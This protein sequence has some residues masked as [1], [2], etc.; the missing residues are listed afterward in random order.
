[1]STPEPVIRAITPEEREAGRQLRV[2]AFTTKARMEPD[3]EDIYA[4]DLRRIGAFVEDRMVTHT[5][6]WEFGQWFLGRRVPMAGI[7]GVASSPEARG[8]GYGRLA[9][10]ALVEQCLEDGDVVSALY[11][12]LPSFYRGLGWAIGGVWLAR[13]LYTEGLTALPRPAADVVVRNIDQEADAGDIA[14]LIDRVAA[15][16]HGTLDRGE[17]FHRRLLTPEDNTL[18]HVA[19]RNGGI[20]GFL[21]ASKKDAKEQV[22]GSVP[23]RLRVHDVVADDRDSWLALWWAI[24]SH[25]PVCTTTEFVSRPHEPLLDL[26]PTYAID[27]RMDTFHWM[28]RILDAPGAIAARGWPE[29]ALAEVHLHVHDEWLDRNDGDWVLRVKD[30]QGELEP[31]GQGIVE[32]DIGTFSSLWTGYA[33]PVD[34]AW[35]G[36]LR[37]AGAGDLEALTEAFRSPRPWCDVFF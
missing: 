22:D 13:E 18:Q 2:M 29:G 16:G 11:P 25:A 15:L 17:I 34:L 27:T 6:A 8:R 24:A 32:L 14:A 9:M 5:A 21:S 26:L 10:R 30:G 35:Q 12:S 19:V 37:G 4:P 1:M 33:Q 31:G 20:T 23:F 36:R 7:G 3:D 28:Q